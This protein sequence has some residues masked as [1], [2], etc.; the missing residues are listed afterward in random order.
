[1][2]A[3]TGKVGQIR[4]RTP[5]NEHLARQAG[6]QAGRQPAESGYKSQY[7]KIGIKIFCLENPMNASSIRSKYNAGCI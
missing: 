7:D 4:E 1:L 5:F 3:L 2:L 6:R